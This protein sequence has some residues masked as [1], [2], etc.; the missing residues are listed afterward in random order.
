MEQP[1]SMGPG[2]Y[3]P[4]M[5]VVSLVPSA[6]ELLC[7]IGGEGWLVGRSH[8]CD[9]PASIADRAVLTSQTTEF[10]TSAEVDRAVSRSLAEGTSLYR[11]DVDRLRALRPDLI[12]TQDL[13]AVCS[14]DLDAVRRVAESLTPR[15][16]ILSLN[17]TTFEQVLDD[18]LA[19]GRAVGLEREAFAAVVGLRERFF[20]AADHVNAMVDPVPCVF[21][22]WTDPPFIAGHWTVQLLERAGAAHPLNP[23]SAMPGAG[24][25]AGGQMAHRSAGHSRRVSEDELA[26]VRAGAVIVCPC[27][28]GL[29]QVRLEFEALRRRD[30]LR[31]SPAWS[32]GKIALVD[33]NQMFNRP[34]PRLVDAYEWLVGWLNDRADLMPP[35]FPWTPGKPG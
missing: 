23:T 29:G 32:R 35:D 20:R 24:A 10:T 25:G 7:L 1:R 6:T 12:I 8:E 2:H 4:P 19:I 11:L 17:P 22:E 18:A 30:W 3:H 14:I 27:G 34:G 16:Q 5:R 9:F 33:G 26:S 15:P 13:C 21:L 31:E 28:L